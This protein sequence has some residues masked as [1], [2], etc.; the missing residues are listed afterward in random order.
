MP[1]MK[2]RQAHL[3]L[4]LFVLV[5]TFGLFVLFTHSAMSI[6]TRRVLASVRGVFMMVLAVA[7]GGYR[8]I[9]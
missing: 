3:G 9:L 5:V 1:A 6:P 7:L 2:L 8:L 4:L